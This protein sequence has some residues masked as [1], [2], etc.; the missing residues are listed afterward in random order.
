MQEPAAVAEAC[1]SAAALEETLSRHP[2][3]HLIVV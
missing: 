2:I 1:R 3:Y